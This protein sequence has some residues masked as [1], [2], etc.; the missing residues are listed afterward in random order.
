M[1]KYCTNAQFPYAVILKRYFQ[2]KLLII[3]SFENFFKLGL[4]L[5]LPEWIKG[6]SFVFES[7]LPFDS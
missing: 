6:V 3:L 4:L 2:I 5:I 1:Y 7:N